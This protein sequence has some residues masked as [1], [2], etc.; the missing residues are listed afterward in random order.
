MNGRTLRDR[1]LPAL[2]AGTRREALPNLPGLAV[3][4]ARSALH[5][6]SLAGQS[7]RFEQP[8]T[9]TRFTVERWPCDERRILPDDLRARLIRLLQARSCAEGSELALAF[10]FDRH[11]LRPHPF[12][13][14]KMG[15]FVRKYPEHLGV[16]AQHW[17]QR[18]TM[19]EKRNE[20]FDAD[21]INEKNWTEA[22]RARRVKFL[23]E[24]RVQ[25][26]AAARELMASVWAHEDPETRVRLLATMKTGLAADDKV[27]LQTIEKDRAPRVRGLVQRLLSRLPGENGENPALRAALSRIQ[28]TQ[29]GKLRKGQLLQLELP[30][31]VKEQATNRWVHD[32]FVDVSLEELAGALTL[33]PD[34]L[35]WQAEDD[36]NL[37]FALGLMGSREKQ[38]DLLASIAVHVS[39]LWSRMSSVDLEEPSFSNAAERDRWAASLLHPETW[40]PEAATPGWTW[41]LRRMEGPLP[42]S[43]ME[44]LLHSKW[45]KRVVKNDPPLHSTMVQAIAALCPSRLRGQL[46][47]QVEPLEAEHRDDGLLL[48]EILEGLESFA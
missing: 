24:L 2:I 37:L 13:F 17:A 7:L 8:A 42:A 4:D 46:R 1:I 28:K 5:A 44:E 26:A 12:D 20:Y 48:M 33:S 30:A 47:A 27:F 15:G 3:D 23:E 10:A 34:E 29:A 45:W 40:E 11:R 31:N 35:V 6:L 39:D 21:D 18:D 25:N 19:V 43:V 9:Q 36:P 38:F 14:P 22:P 16:T 32:E 41:L